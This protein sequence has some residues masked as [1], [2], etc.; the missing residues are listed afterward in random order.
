MFN[1]YT[2]NLCASQGQCCSTLQNDNYP[3]AFDSGDYG[4]WGCCPPFKDC[5]VWLLVHTSKLHT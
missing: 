4:A 2:V 3:D 5:V 1:N